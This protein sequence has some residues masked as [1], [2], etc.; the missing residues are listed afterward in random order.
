MALAYGW[1]LD[2]IW[3]SI[4]PRMVGFLMQRAAAA[5]ARDGARLVGAMHAAKPAEAQRH[6]LDVSRA[7]IEQRKVGA[8]E[9]QAEL[10]SLARHLGADRETLK[11][12]RFAQVYRYWAEKKDANG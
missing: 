8:A 4:S 5:E 2:Y 10:M 12:M 9:G 1:S 7:G 6:Y 3:E 11:G